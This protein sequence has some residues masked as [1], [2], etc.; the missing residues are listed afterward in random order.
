MR[1]DW[2][3]FR[4][5]E[6]ENFDAMRTIAVLPTAAIEQHGPHLPVGTDM[7]IGAGMIEESRALLPSDLKVVFLPVQAVGK[8]NEHIWAAGTISLSAPTALKA[9]TEI[10][11]SV[12]RSG[13]RKLIVTNSH[14]G[15]LDIVSILLRELRV[16]A[17]MLAIKC[18]WGNFGH[19]PGMY[20]DWELQ[21]GI[22]GGDVETSLMLYFRPQAVDMTAAACFRSLA[23]TAPVPPVGPVNAGWIARDLNEQGVVGNAAAA[24]REKG[25][26]TARHQVRGFI[27]LLK[28][29][30]DMPLHR[31]SSA[32]RDGIPHD[33]LQ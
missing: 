26:A 14:G 22:H 4:A 18:Q 16:R 5:S 7:Y 19:P 21:Y 30:A 15:N 1:S 24:S 9:W 6:F 27:D 23:E 33:P 10:G 13:V 2:S 3:E 20:S 29:V 28:R 25:K 12:A 31:S 32:V 17:N 8:S 11:L